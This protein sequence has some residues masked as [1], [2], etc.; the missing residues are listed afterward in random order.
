VIGTIAR[1]ARDIRRLAIVMLQPRAQPAAREF[2]H[3]GELPPIQASDAVA[4]RPTSTD[5]RSSNTWIGPNRPWVGGCPSA[6]DRRIG[7]EVF[8]RDVALFLPFRC[9]KERQMTASAGTKAE[10]G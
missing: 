7:V 9:A 3:D 10:I 4:R 5:R 1:V 2:D 6:N 8:L